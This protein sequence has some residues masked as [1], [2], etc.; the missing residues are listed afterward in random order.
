MAPDRV[1]VPLP[2]LVKLP[3]PLTT[4]LAVISPTALPI[5]DALPNTI[6]PAYV[7]AVLLALVKAPLPLIPEPLKVKVLVLVI[8][9]PFKSSAEPSVTETAPPESPRAVALPIFKVPAEMVVPPVYV[10]APDRVNA[11]P[12]PDLDRAVEPPIAPVISLKEEVELIVKVE[13]LETDPPID[14][15]PVPE[16]MV[17]E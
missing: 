9:V 10:F 1:T 13:A 5:E 3:A 12:A 8:V 17:R 11:P 15:L 6:L 2:A 7:A 16:L 14:D 4:P